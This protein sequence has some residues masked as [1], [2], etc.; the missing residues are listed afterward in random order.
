M[1]T[2]QQRRDPPLVWQLKHPPFS[3]NTRLTCTRCTTGLVPDSAELMTTSVL[4]MMIIMP[5]TFTNTIIIWV[6]RPLQIQVM[7]KASD[8]NNAVP[9]WHH[10]MVRLVATI[11]P[12]VI[13]SRTG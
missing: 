10:C 7:G 8:H 5:G 11:I 2:I 3:N 13:I 12:L 6:C 1:T 9:R 4:G